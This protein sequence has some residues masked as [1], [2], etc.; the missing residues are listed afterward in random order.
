M[1][2]TVAVFA[3]AAACS[4]GVA[5]PPPPRPPARAPIE[6]RGF[7]DAQLA[8]SRVALEAG[9][10]E[11]DVFALRGASK[12]LNLPAGPRLQVALTGDRAIQ[13]APG[14]RRRWRGG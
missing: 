3:V 2:G 4:V 10:L 12:Q 14:L 8:A 6:L 1:R 9:Q 11:M 13:S 7:G 5:Q